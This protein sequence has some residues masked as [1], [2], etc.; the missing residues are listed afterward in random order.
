AR[1]LL[2]RI[3]HRRKRQMQVQQVMNQPAIVCHASDTAEKAA[4]L[5]WEHDCGA[6][7]IVDEEDRVVGIVTDRDICMA[8][9]TQGSP[10]HSILVKS[11]M[12]SVVATC[13]PS[14]ELEIAATQMQKAQVHRLPVVDRDQ[15]IVGILSTHDIL[16]EAEQ[17]RGVD[18]MSDSKLVQVL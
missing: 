4:G 13:S 17:H 16:R 7:P 2:R 14:D 3:G 10:L 12:A 9:F 15:R 1:T 8:A 5:M 11:V 18:S 6:I